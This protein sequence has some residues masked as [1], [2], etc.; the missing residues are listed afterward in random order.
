MVVS[1]GIDHIVFCDEP[2]ESKVWQWRPMI[3]TS[4]SY[5]RRARRYKILSHVYLH[6]YR[7]VFWMDGCYMIRQDITKLFTR[8][9]RD[10]DFAL[11][12][13]PWRKPSCVYEEA[14]AC[15]RCLKGDPTEV[16]EQAERYRKLGFPAGTGVAVTGLIAR[17]H[18]KNVIEFNEAWWEELQNA[19]DRDQLSFPF[20]AWQT[21]L[22]YRLVEPPTATN[23]HRPQFV[24]TDHG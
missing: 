19:S 22:K 20:V 17:R 21:G 9:L 5:R 16:V 1:P 24:W 10:H 11:R 4:E 14:R 12:H 6:E 7:E 15:L 3:K 18:T 2:V 23:D 8:W 13:H